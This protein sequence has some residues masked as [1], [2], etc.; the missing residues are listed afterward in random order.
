MLKF[1]VH[2]FGVNGEV[3]SWCEE[4]DRKVKGAKEVNRKGNQPERTGN[5]QRREVPGNET[6]RL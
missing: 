4:G 5:L 6:E 3:N 1:E 2:E